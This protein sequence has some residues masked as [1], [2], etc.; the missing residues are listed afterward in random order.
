MK[1]LIVY[2]IVIVYIIVASFSA[3]RKEPAFYK[4]SDFKKV[5]KIDAHFHYLTT[6]LVYMEYAASLNFKLITPIWDGEEV[7]IKDQLMISESVYNSYPD[8]YAFFGTF[9]VDSFNY[10]GFAERTIAHIQK[11]LHDGASGIKIWKNI[12]MVL[13][14][15]AGRYV[16]IDNPA[17]EPVFQYLEKNKIPV[18]A[19]LGEPKDCWLPLNQMDD[20]GDVSYY[21]NN[22]QYYMYLH[23][24]V[25][26]YEKQIEARDNILKKYPNLMFTGA[27]LGSLEWSIDEL[28]KRFDAYPNFKADIAAR[29]FHLQLQS[30]KDY[31]KVRNFMIRYQDRLVYGT[32]N[33]VHDING[34]SS[35][36]ICKD[37]EQGWY[38]QW[39]YFATDSTVNNIKGLKLPSEVIDKMYCRNMEAI[40]KTND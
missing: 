14:D 22:P 13:K 6:N 3:C 33:E 16:M 31:E 1:K 15:T 4:A 5:P 36:E 18:I 25:P 40:F 7:S 27:H 17:F 9:P 2:Q 8:N 29:I 38:R 34:L 21:K 30:G 35:A 19:H 26:S 10:P 11:C 37:L 12:G 39:L 20:P 24:D 32:D 23:T 28:A